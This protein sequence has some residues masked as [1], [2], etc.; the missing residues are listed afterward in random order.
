MNLVCKYEV[1]GRV[2]KN[3]GGL[4]LHHKRMHWAAEK[5]VGFSCERYGMRM[6]TEV[7]KKNRQKICSEKMEGEGRAVTRECGNCG[8]WIVVRHYSSHV[9]RSLGEIGWVGGSTGRVREWYLCGR[10]MS[11]SNFERHQDGKATG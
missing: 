4:A 9:G 10:V 7:A 8:D 1:C 6:E 2:C 3:K 11:A 5:K